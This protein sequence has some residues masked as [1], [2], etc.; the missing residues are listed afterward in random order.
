MLY[1]A[2]FGIRVVLQG[3]TSLRAYPLVVGG[4]ALLLTLSMSLPFASI[5]VVAVLL[6][7]G[8]ENLRLV[9]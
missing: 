5:L 8:V 6:R 4:V 2:H 7:R 1:G 9:Q 3:A